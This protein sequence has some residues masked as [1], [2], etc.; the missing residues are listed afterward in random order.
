MTA[1]NDAILKFWFEENNLAG[2]CEQ[3][4]FNAR[5]SIKI[6]VVL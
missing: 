3:M 2:D 1:L 6:V 4:S 5:V